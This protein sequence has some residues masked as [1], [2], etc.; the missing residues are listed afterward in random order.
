[1]LLM[2]I[3]LGVFAQIRKATISSVMSARMSVRIEQLVFHWT[4]FHEI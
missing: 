2:K 1:M 3:I 4:D